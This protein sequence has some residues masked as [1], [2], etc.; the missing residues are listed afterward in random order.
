MV[1]ENCEELPD[2]SLDG[3]LCYGVLYYMTL[4]ERKQAINLMWRKLMTGAPALIVVRSTKDSRYKDRSVGRATNEAG[5]YMDFFTPAKL[6]REFHAFTTLQ[7]DQQLQTYGAE[8]D[9]DYIITLRK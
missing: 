5:M 4:P 6:R 9:H 2:D 7:I 3:V 1:V 8:V